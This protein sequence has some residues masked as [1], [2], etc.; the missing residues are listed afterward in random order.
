MRCPGAQCHHPVLLCQ[1]SAARRALLRSALIQLWTQTTAHSPSPPIEDVRGRREPAAHL[2]AR[3]PSDDMAEWKVN[4]AAATLAKTGR[5]AAKGAASL[6]A[7]LIKQRDQLFQEATSLTQNSLVH[8]RREKES[9]SYPDPRSSTGAHSKLSPAY[10]FAS[11]GHDDTVTESSEVRRARVSAA[12]LC[13][14]ASRE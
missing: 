8:E 4:P 2:A 10:D 13:L 14:L 12:H 11:I 3:P 9:L 5:N 7:W 1:S 6:P